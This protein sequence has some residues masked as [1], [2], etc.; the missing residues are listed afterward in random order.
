MH[1]SKASQLFEWPNSLVPMSPLTS[2]RCK[3]EGSGSGSW[4]CHSHV[5]VAWK[6][7]TLVWIKLLIS[8]PQNRKEHGSGS[9]ITAAFEWIVQ[10]PHDSHFTLLFQGFSQGKEK[11]HLRHLRCKAWRPRCPLCLG[12]SWSCKTGQAGYSPMGLNSNGGPLLYW[13]YIAIYNYISINWK[14][15]APSSYI[16]RACQAPCRGKMNR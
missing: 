4:I 15:Q 6:G 16:P 3:H 2:N 8:K 1:Q 9:P 12:R 13:N 5:G 7:F 10:Y 14:G 11:N